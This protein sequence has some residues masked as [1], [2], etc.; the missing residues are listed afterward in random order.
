MAQRVVKH[1]FQTKWIRSKP[2]PTKIKERIQKYFCRRPPRPTNYRYTSA[3][4]K[5]REAFRLPY[6]VNPFHVNDVIRHYSHPD[7]SPGLPYTKEGLRR[8]DEVDPNR[9]KWAVHA[10]KYG[11]WTK[12]KTPCNAVAKTAV[13]PTDEKLRLIWVYPAHMTFAE[14]MFA[15]PLIRAYKQQ[16]GSP[17]G[18]WIR[19]QCGDMRYLRSKKLPEYTWLAAD[20]SGFDATV[21]PWIIRDAFQ[22][23]LENLDLSRYEFRGIPTDAES[24]PRLWKTILNYFI[25]T[26]IKDPDGKVRIKAGGVPSGSYFTNL[27][28]SIV[29]YIAM[30]YLLDQKRYLPSAF[31]VMGDDVLVA[32]GKARL[33]WKS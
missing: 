26:P 31:Y 24:L 21:P 8:K 11:I 9:I 22:I 7:R 13:H 33:V 28:D 32:I 19:Y 10:M 30:A 14:G 18:I 1:P 27:V 15:M 6:R 3:L 29:N 23:L 17:Y 16:L 20:W 12:C 4:F 25:N 5:A 2:N